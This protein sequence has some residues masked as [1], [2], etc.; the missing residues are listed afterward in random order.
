MNE[1]LETE[2]MKGIV[3]VATIADAWILTTGLNSGVAKLVGDGIAQSRLLS[4]QQKEVIA[5]GLTQWGSLTEKTRSLFKQ[6]CI[7]ENEAEQNIIGT[8]LLN[9]RDSETLEWNHTYSLMFDNG[10]LNTYLSDYQRSAFVQAAVNDLNDPD[11]PH[12][13]KYCV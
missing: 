5:I 3:H 6:I 2:F 10:Q 13:S 1:R 12:H 9:L 4:K 8:K 7:T 11:N